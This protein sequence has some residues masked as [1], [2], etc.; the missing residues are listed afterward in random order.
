MRLPGDFFIFSLPPWKVVIQDSSCSFSIISTTPLFPLLS[1][2]ICVAGQ[3]VR[4]HFIKS[5]ALKREMKGYFSVE[6]E[7]R[8]ATREGVSHA[9][10]QRTMT[11]PLSRKWV[12][13]PEGSDRRID[14]IR[15]GSSGNWELESFL[16]YAILMAR[17]DEFILIA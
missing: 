15:F 3:K 1:N 16:V 5:R 8:T 2:S 7:G 13:V 11:D 6:E 10:N 9:S 12:S 4:C 17:K 14:Q